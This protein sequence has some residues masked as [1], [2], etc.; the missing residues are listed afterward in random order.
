VVIDVRSAA[1]YARGHVPG[2][3][4]VP[5]WRAGRA[6]AALELSADAEVVLYCGHGPRARIAAAAL[7]RR[8]LRRVSLL[9]GHWAGWLEARLPVASASS[10]LHAKPVD[11]TS[12]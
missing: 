6:I 4:H 1:E 2:A 12:P 11:R 7:R 10:D 3:A 9:D 5:F 8:G